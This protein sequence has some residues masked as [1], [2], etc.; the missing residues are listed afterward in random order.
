M[1]KLNKEKALGRGYDVSDRSILQSLGT[2]SGY[3]AVL[4][5]ALYINSAEVVMLYPTPEILWMLCPIILYWVTR[6]WMKT[7]RG[8]MNEDPILFALKDKN[9]WFVGI[10]ALSILIL[11]TT[12]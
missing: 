1:E 11:A 5:M 4:V 8:L 10:L 2:S 7:A 9:S 6:V 12:Y 3:M